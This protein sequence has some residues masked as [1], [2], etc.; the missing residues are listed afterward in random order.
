MN[1][2][3]TV[4]QVLAQTAALVIEEAGAD[5]VVIAMTRQRKG[6]TETYIKPFGN[7]HAVRGVV[8]YAYGRLCED[9]AEAEHEEPTDDG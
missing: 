8:E 6:K 1:T 2:S 3:R 7:Y 5:A 4:N 9:D